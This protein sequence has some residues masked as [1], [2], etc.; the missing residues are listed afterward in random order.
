MHGH[1][2]RSTWGSSSPVTLRLLSAEEPTDAGRLTRYAE[3]L[4]AI[5]HPNVA[6]VYETGTHGEDLFIARERVPGHDLRSLVE[7]H[8][9]LAPETA[10]Q[11]VEQAAT[12]LGE[13]RSGGLTHAYLTP[14]N[15]LVEL[16]TESP[17]AYVVDLGLIPERAESGILP[18][19]A[20]RGVR[21]E[22]SDVYALGTLLRGELTGVLAGESADA[23][24]GGQAPSRQPAE[25]PDALERVLARA[26]RDDPSERYATPSTLLQAVHRAVSPAVDTPIRLTQTSPGAPPEQRAERPRATARPGD[27]AGTAAAPRRKARKAPRQTAHGTL[28]GAGRSRTGRRGG[29]PPEP[30]RS[31]AAEGDPPRSA[32]ALLDARESVVVGR[33]FELTIGLSPTPD[34]RLAGDEEIH[35]PPTSLGTYDLAIHVV[36]PDFRLRRGES[37]RNKL[38]VTAKDPYPR[39]LLHLTAKRIDVDWRAS[40]IQATYSTEGQTMGLAMR[41]V[42]VA[43]SADLLGEAKPKAK[44]QTSAMPSDSPWPTPDLTINILVDPENRENLNWTFESRHR[45]IKIP[46]TQTAVL[47]NK[48]ER[49]AKDL[50]DGVAEREGDTDDADAVY[51]YLKGIGRIVAD[52][53][54]L[55]SLLRDAAKA[56]GGP[57]MVLINS[58]DPY[59]PWELALVS[60][61]LLDPDAPP[62][63]GAQAVVARWVVGTH[64]PPPWPP[65]PNEPARSMSVVSGVYRDPELPQLTA[66]EEEAEQLKQT[67]RAKKVDALTGPVKKCLK[68]S[69]T[70]DVLHFAMHARGQPGGFRNGLLMM[71]G[72]VLA[73]V[74]I[75]G[76][77]LSAPSFVFLNAC[78]AGVGDELL[79]DY[80]GLAAS[81]LRAGAAAVIAPL[82]GIDDGIAKDVALRFYSEVFGLGA[83]VAEYLRTERAAFRDSVETVAGDGEIRQAPSTPLAYIFYGHPAMRL[84]AALPLE[85]DA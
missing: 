63:L 57:P 15:V 69:P 19:E 21:D 49:I 64:R 30:P 75:E 70:P 39:L 67:Y 74:D 3:I 53:M 73:P 36:A 40:W 18:P 7:L 41:P 6:T 72:K 55:G 20:G 35:R 84:R 2:P 83:N 17:H 66:A 78:Q 44:P 22:R 81:F 50:I 77:D 48:P 23:P 54:P 12:A 32:F 14:R 82:W 65:F 71:K 25:L 85:S 42:G 37:W 56:A 13:L 1:T 33:S 9:Q 80:A 52:Q 58:A 31:T 38:R 43:R 24:P 61:P 11:I 27:D 4:K 46:E 62:F 68:S 5:D 26:L 47:G 45:K 51:D 34:P 28:T 8:G 10:I 79:G 16:P 59:V 29:D 76:I 60:E